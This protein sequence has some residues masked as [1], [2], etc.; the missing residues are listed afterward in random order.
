MTYPG[1]TVVSKAEFDELYHDKRRIRGA[2]LDT[3]I[4][5]LEL[6]K[7]VF[8][9]KGE[10]VRDAVRAMQEHHI[11]CILVQDQGRLIGIF[12]E[13]DVLNEVV[14]RD[15][16]QDV[17]IESVMTSN[18]ESLPS[19]ASIAYAMN[20]MCVGGFRHIPVV[21]N[22]QLAIGVVSVR[23]IVSLLVELFPASVLNLPCHP[24]LSVAK[25]TDGG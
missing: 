24:E 14:Y 17:A 12:T 23:D 16:Q 7:P 25:E 2:I 19:S 1:G 13:R 21:D 4:S 18:P 6:R 8:V 11:G 5:E 10:S 20:R 3:A 22:D 15:D 9:E